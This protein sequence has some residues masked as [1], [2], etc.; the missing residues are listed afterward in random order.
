MDERLTKLENTSRDPYGS[1]GSKFANNVSSSA[2]S[3]GS[4]FYLP[5]I[6]QIFIIEPLKKS[7]AVGVKLMYD[8]K[9]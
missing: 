8:Q 6:T 9:H 4:K 5:F 1:R 2:I 7:L 3:R